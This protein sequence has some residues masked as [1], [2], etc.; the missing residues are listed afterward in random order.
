MWLQ[1][2]ELQKRLTKMLSMRSPVILDHIQE[3][4]GKILLPNINETT[5]ME[6]SAEFVSSKSLV[7][8]IT[9]RGRCLILIFKVLQKNYIGFTYLHSRIE[10]IGQVK[11]A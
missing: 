3:Y 7:I 5:E 6:I 1:G 8:I 11:L 2:S 9:F 4:R 10:G